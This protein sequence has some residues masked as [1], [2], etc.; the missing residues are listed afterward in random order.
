M[1]NRLDEIRHEIALA[2]RM[3]AHENVLDAFGHVSMRH[4]TDPGRYFLSRSRSPQLLEPGDILEYTLELG[5]GEAAVLA[6][7]RRARDPR[8]HLRG[9]SRR[10]GGLPPSR[11]GG[12]AVLRR[13]RA[14]R[15][16]VPPRRRERR[17]H[18]VLGSAGRV[19][20]HQ[21]SGADAGGRAFARAGARKPFGGAAQPPWRHGRRRRHPRARLALHLHVP[22]R[23]VPVAGAHA[24]QGRQAHAG[25]GQ[26][27][28]HAQC[29]AER[30]RPDLGI[31]DDAAGGSRP[32]AA[33]ARRSRRRRRAGHQRKRP[34]AAR[35]GADR[36]R[37][38]GLRPPNTGARFSRNARTPSA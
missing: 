12:A 30:H 10:D 14:D 38:R 32:A 1:P 17:D 35:S 7:V 9:A 4:P 25:R 33:A 29:A 11:G 18:A 6:D 28:E 21:S 26:A 8:L 31:L 34:S 16:G 36:L 2:S 15:A 37:Q 22:E 24:R 5:A 27:R 3:L 19:R 20:R 23:G 13:R